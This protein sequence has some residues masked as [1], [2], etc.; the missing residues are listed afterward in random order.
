MKKKIITFITAFCLVMTMMPIYSMEA[1][2]ASNGNADSMVAAAV[3]AKGKS[4][5]E[6]GLGGE[7]CA[8]FIYYCARKSGNTGKIGDSIW[9]GTQAKQTVNDK[10][11][12]ITFVNKSA[13]NACKNR[14][15]SARCKY[16]PSYVPRKG[17]LYIQKGEDHGDPYFAHV[18][19]V[20][21]NSDKSSIAYTIEGNTSCDDGKHRIFNNV[22]YKTR[23]K[24]YMQE[25]YGFSAFITPKYGNS[26]YV[27]AGNNASTGSI[28]L[29]WNKYPKAS[30]YYVYAKK[31]SASKYTLVKKT[32]GTSYTYKGVASYKYNFKV[33]AISS[34]GKKLNTSSV[35][36]RT[37]DLAQPKI[38]GVSNIASTGKIKVTWADVKNA[39]KYKVYRATSKN[40]KY[41]LV[42]TSAK[43]KM[44]T[45]KS[46][47]ITLGNEVPGQVYFYKVQAL[48]TSNTGADSALSKYG[49]Q[50][51]DLARPT[52]KINQ[53]DDY[54]NLS[55]EA[56]AKADKYEIYRAE[57]KSGTYSKIGTVTG[58]TFADKSNLTNGKT[59]YYKVRAL[60]NNNTY[61][62]SAY[63][64][65]VWAEYTI[66]QPI[67]EDFI[68]TEEEYKSQYTDTGKYDAVPVY[69]YATRQKEY[70]T[71]GYNSISSNNGNT[72]NKYD[73]KISSTIS[74][75]TW[76][77]PVAGTTYSNGKRKDVSIYS[78]KYYYYFYGAAQPNYTSRWTWY[79]NNSRAGVI[80]HL[81]K[82][83]SN[84]S[85]W[86]EARLRYFWKL[87][88]VKRSNLD[89]KNT[90]VNYVNDSTV[91]KGYFSYSG[92][93]KVYND[94]HMYYYKPVYKSK[95]V[96]TVNYFWRWGSW[97]NWSN[98]TTE[99]KAASDTIKKDNTR[100]Y[101]ITVR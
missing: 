20:R 101:R 81:K 99:Q 47:Y 17:D 26:I 37:C 73:S 70:T 79:V 58:K 76:T 1:N 63:S 3:N 27:T 11:G 49:Y 91:N 46:H 40:G 62:S 51:C 66:S 2:A 9:V 30:K 85:V 23:N 22:E 72:W 28:N 87:D 98:W 43:L 19:L 42:Y 54:I 68:V 6:L 41:S 82:N 44:N 52:V 36:S 15:N 14:F 89:V 16:N 77:K 59:Y 100:M 29:T 78:T 13:Y 34:K 75:W 33:Q 5:S 97:S 74:N 55:W 32:S 92:T 94:I 4:V 88:S 86:G 60:L 39:N 61:A 8:Q 56:V 38:T 48:T 50:T 57:S 90:S 45:G 69:R 93:Y 83:Y 71:S 53:K 10:G 96:T 24:K 80:S 95:I 12:T 84:S 7:W 35:V 64:T 25:P 31:A 67:S 65:V 18:G 21:K